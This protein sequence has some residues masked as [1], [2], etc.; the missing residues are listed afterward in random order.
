MLDITKERGGANSS[1]GFAGFEGFRVRGWVLGSRSSGFGFRV[2]GLRISNPDPG[3]RIPTPDPESRSGCG[4]RI[5]TPDPESRPRI[6]SPDPG[7]RVPTRIP[8]PG[9]RS[10]EPG[11]RIPDPDA[12]RRDPQRRK[13]GLSRATREPRESGAHETPRGRT[14]APA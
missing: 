12:D 10:P 4:S 7:T 5:P 6:P 3:S 9:P 11:P 8:D 13:T 2:P 14:P 1:L